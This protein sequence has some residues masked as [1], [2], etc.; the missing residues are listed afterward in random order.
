MAIHINLCRAPGGDLSTIEK[1]RTEEDS[2]PLASKIGE[3]PLGQLKQNGEIYNP[4][5]STPQT[6]IFGGVLI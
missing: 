2:P 6:K 5:T 4:A 1:R 3:N